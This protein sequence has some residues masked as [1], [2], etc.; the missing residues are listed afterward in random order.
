MK[1][2]LDIDDFN[3]V[4]PRLDVFLK[5][6]EHFPDFKVSMFT[7][8][9]PRKCDYGPYLIKDQTLEEVKKHLDWIQIIPHGFTHEHSHEMEHYNYNTFKALIPKIEEIFNK[10]GVPFV[11][12]FKAPHWRWSK[13]VV[14]ALDEL[15]W[16]GAVLREDKM[17]KTKRF[18]RYTHLLNEPFWESDLEVLKLHGHVFGTKNDIGRCYE[19]MLKLPKDTQFYYVTDFIETL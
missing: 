13:G 6:K 9:A 17:P 14:D 11:K 19:N 2:V 8:P 15:G 1:V 7:I 10:D 5:L 4:N 3:W 18:Y 12:G 16:W